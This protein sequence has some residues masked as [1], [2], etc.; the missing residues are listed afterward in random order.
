[1]QKEDKP[2]TGGHS[3]QSGHSKPNGD[4]DKRE[5]IE[6]SIDSKKGA[7]TSSSVL[8]EHQPLALVISLV[9]LSFCFLL[10]L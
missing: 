5:N 6:T 3:G 8:I 1:M 2:N 4:L 10:C 9:L 7:W